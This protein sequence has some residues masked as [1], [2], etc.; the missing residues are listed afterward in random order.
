MLGQ[1]PEK[2]VE[3]ISVFSFQ[4]MP[5]GLFI[6]RRCIVA[7]QPGVVKSAGKPSGGGFVKAKGE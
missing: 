4:L 2:L 1:E 7:R 6:Q 3:S 5:A